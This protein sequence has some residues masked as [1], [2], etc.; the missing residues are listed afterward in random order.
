MAGRELVVVKFGSE[1]VTDHTGIAHDRIAHYASQLSQ[2]AFDL[3]VVSSGAVKTGEAIWRRQHSKKHATNESYATLGNARVTAAWQ[4]AFERHGRL[5]G[6]M[7]ATHQEVK[8]RKEGPRFKQTL[9]DNLDSGIISILNE[10]DA[11][12]D[13][14]MVQYL[15]G[16]DNDELAFEIAKTMGASALMLMTDVPG[17][18][19]LQGGV[20]SQVS[21]S[22]L[23]HA[24][25]RGFAGEINERGQG[26]PTKVG[27]AIM[28][29][30]IGI[31]SYIAAAG[32][33][34][35]AVL[36]GKTGSH[37]VAKPQDM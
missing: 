15:L 1:S 3:I 18:L 9:A 31:E 34:L 30:E 6:G 19:D 4:D 13:E 37:F 10:N 27:A 24:R 8:S 11:V 17:L 28:A 2:T 16:G 7:L 21:Y 25:A 22:P 20:V 23:E 32:Q 29:A 14:E 5:A 12:N 36:S 35:E 33:N 26:M